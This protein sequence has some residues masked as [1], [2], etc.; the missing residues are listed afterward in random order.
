MILESETAGLGRL[1]TI[2]RADLASHEDC[3]QDG[4]VKAEAHLYL[5]VK[6]R[7]KTERG[8]E[9]RESNLRLMPQPSAIELTNAGMI[10]VSHHLNFAAELFQR[11][12]EVVLIAGPKVLDSNRGSCTEES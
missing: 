2:M 4:E 5:S 9:S 6:R 10:D 3:R 7:E 8:Q 12:F 11:P 1:E